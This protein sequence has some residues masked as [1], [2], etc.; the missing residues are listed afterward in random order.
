MNCKFEIQVAESSVKMAESLANGGEASR[1]SAAY[2][3]A[4]KKYRQ[5]AEMIPDRRDE[6]ECLADKYESLANSPLPNNKSNSGS[7]SGSAYQKTGNKQAAKK[8]DKEAKAT[9]P[10]TDADRRKAFQEG[11]DELNNLIGIKGVKEKVNKLIKVKKIDAERI[12]QGLPVGKTNQHLVFTG[13]PGTGKTTVAR[14]I[15]KLYFGLGILPEDKLVET[16]RS[17]LVAGYIGQTAPKT[18]EKIEEAL[19]GVL[20]ID[21]AYA[22]TKGGENDFGKEAID[23][24]LKEMEDNRDKLVVVVAGYMHPMENFLEANEGLRSR[25]KN[26]IDFE[27]Y[28]DEEL[29]AIFDM[30]CKKNQSIYDK[31]CAGVLK[32]ILG[33]ERSLVSAET[34]GNA[35]TL[36]NI[37]ED[38]VENQKVRLSEIAHPSKQDL[39]TLKKEDFECVLAAVKKKTKR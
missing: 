24:L 12:A 13:N 32:K 7:N 34:F 9:S 36:R 23:T 25:F 29:I 21:E 14:I 26:V 39:M 28:S 15:A 8:D 35:R 19:G 31:E 20:F 2:Q 5:L 3:R 37:Y 11:L 16:D 1:A 22:L 33:V 18:K 4:A 30:M 38:V 17:G 6:F 10:A 27:D